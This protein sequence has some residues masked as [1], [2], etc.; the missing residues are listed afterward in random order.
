MNKYKIKQP[1]K[2]IYF[3]EQNPFKEI[4]KYL[5]KV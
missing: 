1:L 5:K 3:K 2:C 4:I